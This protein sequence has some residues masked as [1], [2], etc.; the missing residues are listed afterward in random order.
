MP[1][2]DNATY[3]NVNIGGNFVLT[4]DI[5]LPVVRKRPNDF[6]ASDGKIIHRIRYS[7]AYTSE[8][9][10]LVDKRNHRAQENLPEIERSLYDNKTLLT[11]T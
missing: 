9:G 3:D 8:R 10:T 1:K 2:L 5:I 11:L 4:P 6:I 7:R